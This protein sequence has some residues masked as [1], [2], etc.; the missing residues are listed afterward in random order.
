VG[1][2]GEGGLGGDGVETASSQ[3]GGAVYRALVQDDGV[4]FREYRA[5]NQLGF[6][7]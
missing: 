6:V 2:D 7:S 3:G 1:L 5:G 4:S